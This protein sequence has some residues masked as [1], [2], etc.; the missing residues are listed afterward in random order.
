MR[1]R[2]RRIVRKTYWN[3][4]G[5]AGNKW[6][7]FMSKRKNLNGLPQNWIDSFWDQV[8]KIDEKGIYNDEPCLLWGI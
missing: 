2:V 1:K 4:N 5:M 7:Q 8:E 6:Q 3:Q